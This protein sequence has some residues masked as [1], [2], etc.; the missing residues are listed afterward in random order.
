MAGKTPGTGTHQPADQQPLGAGRADT[1]SNR[2]VLRQVLRGLLLHRLRKFLQAALD[3]CAL[4]DPAHCALLCALGHGI[5]S[6][7]AHAPCRD[8]GVRIPNAQRVGNLAAGRADHP[9]GKA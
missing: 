9:G 3:Q 4:C 6:R 5:R 1:L 7:S 2:F 8:H